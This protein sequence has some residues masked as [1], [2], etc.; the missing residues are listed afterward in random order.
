MA[1]RPGAKAILFF[2]SAIVTILRD[3]DPAIPFPNC[4]DLPGGGLDPDEDAVSA[5]TREIEEEIGLIYPRSAFVW[6]RTYTSPAGMVSQFFAGPITAA[7]I[8]AIRLGDE[9]QRWCMMAGREFVGRS[10]VVPHFRSRVAECLDAL[11]L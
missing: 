7:Q 8:G 9:G 2:R 5:V 1:G 4:W 6:Q 3:K 10:D 11:G